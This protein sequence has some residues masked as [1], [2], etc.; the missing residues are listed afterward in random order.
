MA[1]TII[2]TLELALKPEAVEPFCTQIPK[3]LEETRRFPGFV[4]ISIRRHADEPNRVI[5]IEEWESRSAYEAYIAF[6]TESGMMKAMGAM[7]Q[8][9][10]RSECW[11]DMVA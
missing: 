5:F 8:A 1:D 6:R 3:T 11:S 9:P 10:P 7:L 2:V 4:G